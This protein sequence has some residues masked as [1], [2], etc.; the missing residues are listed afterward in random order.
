MK[1]QPRKMSQAIKDGQAAGALLAEQAPHVL[2]TAFANRKVGGEDQTSK[3]W[4]KAWHALHTVIGALANN[5]D[6][7]AALHDLDA[8]HGDECVAHEDRAWHAAWSLANCLHGGNVSSQIDRN[9]DRRSQN[10][11]S[12]AE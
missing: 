9:K 10:R 2:L 12:H 3:R 6:V 8:A 4:S 7:A 11:K 1:V 5:P